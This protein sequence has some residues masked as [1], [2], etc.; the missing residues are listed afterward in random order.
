M[1]VDPA[2]AHLEG[3]GEVADRQPLQTVDGGQRDGGSDDRLTCSFAVGTRPSRERHVDKIARSVVLCPM[4]TTDRAF[5]EGSDHDHRHDR[6]AA[7]GRRHRRA[8]GGSYRCRAALP[9]DPGRSA[10]GAHPA[11][12]RVVLDPVRRAGGD[13]RAE[14]RRKDDAAGD[15]RRHRPGHG[16]LGALRRGRRA[17]QRRSVP[18]RARLRAAG[19]HHPRRP[20]ARAHAALRGTPAA[21]VRDEPGR[22]RR[23]RRRRPRR[24]RARR[25]GRRAGRCAERRAAQAGQHRRRAAHR[26]ARVLPRRADVGPGSADER[27]A[28]H[29]PAP[30]RRPVGDG[31]VHDALRRRPGDV[32]PHRVHDPRRTGRLRRNHRRGARVVRG[33]LGPRPLPRCSPIPSASPNRPASRPRR[34]CQSGRPAT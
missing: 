24:G 13:R 12:H 33:R 19:R 25:P 28:D 21:A 26:S 11:R 14:R 34:W 6:R 27:R 2:L 1:G 15:D 29:P 17:R 31:R 20:A 30:A 18:Q 22:R 8:D 9:A 32:S 5:S 16:G 3:G 4:S 10:G 23:R 7:N